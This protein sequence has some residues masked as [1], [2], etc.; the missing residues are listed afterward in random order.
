MEGSTL[1]FG[2]LCVHGGQEPDPATGSR[3]VP[4]YQ[5]TSYLFDSVDHA[6]NL[7]DLKTPGFIYTRIMNPT[8]GVFENR[9]AMLEGGIGALAVA[10]GQAAETLAILAIADTGDEI[11][12]TTSLYGG[13]YNLF[14]YT[15]PQKFGI[16]VHFVDPRDPENFRRAITPKTRALYIEAIGN[17]KL[18]VHDFEAIANIAHEHGI[19]LIVD[20][21]VPTPIL[22]R[23]FDWGADIVVHSATK[24]IGG[25]GNS[26][27][28]VI[29]DSGKFNWDN[30]KFPQITQPD[31][32]YHGLNFREAFGD[33][34]Y[35]IKVR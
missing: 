14:K 21:T 6:A 28:G 11:V 29:V 18:D 31:P 33:M 5:T 15:F 20:N 2:T 4:I 9:V 26:I 32:S 25:H 17:P 13:T 34:A 27:G 23:P 8:Q 1:R 30:G 16:T 35:I 19:P 12:S 10:S 7:F 3:A 22:L 24:F